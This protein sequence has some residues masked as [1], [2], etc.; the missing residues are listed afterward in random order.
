MPDL[1]L[2]EVNA[3]IERDGAAWAAGDNDVSALPEDDRIRRLGVPL[4]ALPDEGKE[5]LGENVASP[6]APS[7]FDLRSV[8]G[9]SFVGPIRDQGNCGSCVAFGTLAAV[10][11]SACFKLAK[12]PSQFDLSEA[13]LYYCKGGPTGVNCN[14]GWLPSQALPYCTNPGIVDEKCFPY[15]AGDQPCKL[16]ADSASRRF[17][18]KSA[19][20][21]TSRTASIKT[22]I[23]Q[24][25]PVIAC[26]IV[27]Q[28]FFRYK[29]GVYKHVT[30]AQAGGHCVAII[31]YDD[32]QSCWICKNSWGSGWGDKGF[33]KISYGECRIES[34]QNFGISL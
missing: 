4:A 33:F 23:S 24:N 16:C 26:F 31:G 30:G 28:D 22:W 2:D 18:S 7:A 13:D 6:A 9:K 20:A 15:S 34:W 8:N 25:G 21:L 11:G 14:T 12:V 5:E 1:T 32:Q 27:Y 10:E 17:K 19:T 3:A 29:S